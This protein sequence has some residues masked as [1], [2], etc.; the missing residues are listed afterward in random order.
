MTDIKFKQIKEESFGD[1]ALYLEYVLGITKEM[2]VPC[3]IEMDG[4]KYLVTRVRNDKGNLYAC[5]YEKDGKMKSYALS[6]PDNHPEYVSI[7][8][9]VT[10]LKDF[11]SMK[12]HPFVLKENVINDNTEQLAFGYD[13]DDSPCLV[14]FQ[15]D[16]SRN[17]DCEIIYNLGRHKDNIPAYIDYI[18]SKYP[19]SVILTE[20]KKLFKVIKHRKIKSYKYTGSDYLI[21]R[22]RLFGYEFADTKYPVELEDVLYNVELNGFKPCVPT[23]LSDIF[24]H[25][26]A[27]E[28]NMKLLAKVY[29]ENLMKMQ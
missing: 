1:V 17:I 5:S 14:Y 26:S 2:G 28:N 19:K 6:V 25:R 23:Y 18:K 13:L 29:D 11:S 8:D 16:L 22:L 9:G 20:E 21:S 24:T 15:Q 12:I 7:T 3:F 4:T 10:I 27:V